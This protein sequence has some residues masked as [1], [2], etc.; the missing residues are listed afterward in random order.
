MILNTGEAV[1]NFKFMSSTC[2]SSISEFSNQRGL[3]TYL[4][5]LGIFIFNAGQQEREVRLQRTREYVSIAQYAVGQFAFA[6]MGGLMLIVPLIIM[7]YVPGR[8]ASVVT[9]CISVFLFATQLAVWSTM[10][11]ILQ[12]PATQS[13][14]FEAKDIIGATAAYAAVLVVFVGTSISPH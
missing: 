4:K 12:A 9:T 7:V 11:R 2:Q 6:T 8:T 5:D 13:G 14:K 10:A 3:G 1:E